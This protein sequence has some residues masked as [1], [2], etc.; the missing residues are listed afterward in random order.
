MTSRAE[1]LK[2]STKILVGIFRLSIAFCLLTACSWLTGCSTTQSSLKQNDEVAHLAGAEAL[3]SKALTLATEENANTN[4][5]N[6]AIAEALRLANHLAPDNTNILERAMF[7]LV[8]R[9]LYNDAY[10]LTQNYLTR[11]PEARSIRYA[12]ACCADAAG[13]TDLAAQAC[14]KLYAIDPDD[15]E[16]EETLIRLYF[17]S[18]QGARAL[19]MIQTAYERHPDQ[20]SLALPSKWAVHFITRDKDFLRGLHCLNIALAQNHHPASVRSALL[21]LAGECYLQTKQPNTAITNLLAAYET[22]VNNLQPIQRLSVVAIAYPAT[23]NIL[24]ELATDCQHSKP[25]L[26]ALL[27]AVLEQSADNKTAAIESLRRAHEASMVAGY[28]PPEGLYLWRI[29]LLDLAQRSAEAIPILKNALTVHRSSVQLKNTLAYMW[30]EQGTNLEEASKLINEVLQSVPNN[31]AYLD[32]KGWILFKMKRPYDALQY[33][34]KAAELDKDPV[35]FD[36]AGDALAATGMQAEAEE[37]WKKSFELDPKPVV[38][39][40]FKK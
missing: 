2:E 22:D 6:T 29:T 13:K 1:H 28:F 23:T 4:A 7:C 24:Q 32:T 27:S 8:S 11:N 31:A 9:R 15:R 35:V 30:A 16:I 36:H 25:V 3:L 14:E 18:N 19:Q 20:A 39:K 40:K 17:Y 26:S 10:Q 34:L 12:A 38:E 5:I 33:L 37:F 21:T